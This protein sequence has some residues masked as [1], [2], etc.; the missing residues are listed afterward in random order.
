MKKKRSIPYGYTMKNGKLIIDD[1]E[2]EVIKRIF[3]EYRS[4]MSM[5]EMAM[6]LV[7]ETIP[8]C[9]K[10][11]SWNKNVIAR[12]IANEKYA[13][14]EGYLPIIGISEFREAQ[15]CKNERTKKQLI[16][17]DSDIGIIRAKMICGECE[18]RMKRINEPRNKES[19]KWHC[20]NDNCRSVVKID[21]TLL[22]V[23]IQ[24]KLN[25][26]IDN[27]EM[28]TSDETYEK[29][30]NDTLDYI[31]DEKEIKRLCETNNYTDKYLITEIISM[32]EKRYDSYMDFDT[33]TTITIRQ[34]YE[35]ATPTE[36]F[37]AE[38]F[39]QTVRMVLMDKYGN[40][41]ICLNNNIEV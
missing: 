25:L 3:D 24:E 6:E 10:K 8:Y 30:S 16:K 41:T 28:I 21:D 11:V 1:D 37:N 32:A 40:I 19:T 2:A 4:G 23:R 7:R 14:A 9:E 5:Y 18:A 17:S 20:C 29:T 38:L 22:M 26:L 35:K 13:G 31:K 33:E 39:L 12:I 34:A 36:T 27:P 15:A